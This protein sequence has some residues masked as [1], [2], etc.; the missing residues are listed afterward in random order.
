MGHLEI[1]SARFLQAECPSSH[2]ND[3]F[4]VLNEVI[5]SIIK[6]DILHH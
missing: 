5:C 6:L 1:S 2:Q 3:S 4:K